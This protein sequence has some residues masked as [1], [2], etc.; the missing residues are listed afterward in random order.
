L[1]ISSY[2]S[3]PLTHVITYNAMRRGIEHK[4]DDFD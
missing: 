1:K 4:Q 3:V 2:E